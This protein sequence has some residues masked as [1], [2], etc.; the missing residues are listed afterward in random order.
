MPIELT[1]LSMDLGDENA[2]QRSR[3]SK[4]EIT[5]GRDPA[6]DVVLSGKDISD[7]HAKVTIGEDVDSPQIFVTD[8]G[9]TNGTKV[10]TRLLEPNVASALRPAERIM[11][12]SYLI[13]TAV[14]AEQG[15]NGAAAEA[16]PA[17][18]EEVKNESKAGAI[19]EAVKREAEQKSPPEPNENTEQGSPMAKQ[20]DSENDDKATVA[21]HS[22]VTDFDFEA[23]QVFEVSGV[24][25][26]KGK[27]LVGVEVDG[28]ALG[29]TVTDKEGR[30]EFKDVPEDTE[31]ILKVNKPGYRFKQVQGKAG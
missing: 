9:S 3:F 8:L 24:V 20:T 22:N 2:P 17:K 19:L 18:A 13:K 16:T 6:N 10:E 31:Y 30:Y 7:Y 15:K 11:I 26:H 27:P 4:E 1:V 14:V 25:R 29:T 12:G 5:I 28:G 23:T 21:V